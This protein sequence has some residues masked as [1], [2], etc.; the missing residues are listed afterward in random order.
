MDFGDAKHVTLCNAKHTKP[1]LF[2]K[3]KTW[4]KNDKEKAIFCFGNVLALFTEFSFYLSEGIRY[5]IQA[6][7][8]IS[9][10][11]N[12]CC[13]VLIFSTQLLQFIDK[14]LLSRLRNANFFSIRYVNCQYLGLV[15]LLQHF[16]KKYFCRRNSSFNCGTFF[17]KSRICCGAVNPCLLWLQ[18]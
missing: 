18:Y 14:V 15:I 13:E 7:S 16:P 1:K 9:V 6:L 10:K 8:Y 5:L 11:N 4:N 3:W 12:S 17:Y 2:F